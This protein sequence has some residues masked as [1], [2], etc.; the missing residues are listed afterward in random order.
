MVRAYL[1]T[2]GSRKKIVPFPLPGK[3]ASAVRKG[4]LA[5]P[6]NRYG[7]IGWEEFLQGAGDAR[8]RLARGVGSGE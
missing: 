8:L 4:A 2:K 1:K 6:E 3:T 7:R 5:C